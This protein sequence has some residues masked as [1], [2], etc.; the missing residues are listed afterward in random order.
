[1]SAADRQR[2]PEERAKAAERAR[3]WRER[4]K[5]GRRPLLV[6]VPDRFASTLVERAMLEEYEV[7]DASKLAAKAAEIIER[8]MKRA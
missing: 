3:R 8:W 2:S 1:M 5:Q 7:D 4:Q 6:E